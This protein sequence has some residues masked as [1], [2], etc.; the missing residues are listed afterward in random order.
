MGEGDGS[1]RLEGE[2]VEGKGRRFSGRW[3]G[4][5]DGISR[6]AVGIFGCSLFE[7]EKL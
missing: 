6:E 7:M 3:E 4:I 2:V 1:G 5:G